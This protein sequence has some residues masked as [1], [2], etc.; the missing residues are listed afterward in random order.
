MVNQKTNKKSSKGRKKNKADVTLKKP[1]TEIVRKLSQSSIIMKSKSVMEL[2]NEFEPKPDEPNESDNHEPTSG[3]ED[4]ENSSEGEES[5]TEEEEE[6]VFEEAQDEAQDEDPNDLKSILK[7]MNK[8]L[9]KINNIESKVVGIDTT[10]AQILKNLKG[11]NKRIDILEQNEK[12][13]KSLN[14]TRHTELIQKIDNVNSRVDS[15]ENNVTENINEIK[16]D[17]ESLKKS[18]EQALD[19]ANVNTNEKFQSLATRITEIEDQIKT[20][21]DTN[22]IPPPAN[23]EQPSTI[24]MTQ[25]NI[26]TDSDTN[27]SRGEIPKKKV[28]KYASALHEKQSKFEDYRRR[29]A[30]RVE[31]EDFINES[32][33]D[34]SGVAPSVIL[35]DPKYHDL[36]VKT[37]TNK[38]SNNTNIPR[39]NFRISELHISSKNFHIAW[40]KFDNENIVRSIFK[41]SSIIQS[42][43]LNMFPVIPEMGIN[44]KKS[45]ENKLKALQTIDQKLRYQIRLGHSDFKVFLKI[46]HEGEYEKFREIP[47]DYIDPNDEAEKLRTFTADIIPEDEI[48]DDE[49]TENQS[50]EW[51]RLSSRQTR[52]KFR[53]LKAKSNKRVSDTQ[54]LEFIYAYLRGTQITPWGHFLGTCPMEAMEE[55]L[56]NP[57]PGTSS[58]GA[59]TV[60]P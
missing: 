2:A 16:S 5:S 23:L 25:S 53:N 48:S 38:L 12:E 54:I 51:Q 40:I 58:S 46:Y 18:N 10:Q 28:P 20:N 21:K 37:I 6:E 57:T 59:A 55:D 44:R 34:I 49:T 35:R 3:M 9:S 19:A 41:Q 27:K 50:Q 33:H 22:P 42:G 29:L 31:P 36:R 43:N 45:I 11:L 14:D 39:S 26:S 17:I 30:L 52:R 7:S 13:S 32:S 4:A 15:I 1:D 8:K 47:I 56:R 60:M 24:T